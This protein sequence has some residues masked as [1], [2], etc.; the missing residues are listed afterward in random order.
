MAPILILN[1]QGGSINVER[2][3]TAPTLRANSHQHEPVICYGLD[4][5]GQA[6]YKE[7][8][9]TIKANG[10]GDTYPK[11]VIE[12]ARNDRSNKHRG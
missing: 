1:D 6:I 11:V 4:S 8:Y 5:Y 3:N 12:V 2:A 10:G 9:P 7:F